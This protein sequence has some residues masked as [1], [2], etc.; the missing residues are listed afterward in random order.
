M[1]LN[2]LCNWRRWYLA[3]SKH[4]SQIENNYWTLL[5]FD[6]DLLL[7][8]SF[9]QLRLFDRRCYTLLERETVSVES[10][11]LAKKATHLKT[12]SVSPDSPF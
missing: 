12:R 9:G 3:W 6:R 5:R 2:A 11:I 10:N 8:S 7:L 1:I 4:V